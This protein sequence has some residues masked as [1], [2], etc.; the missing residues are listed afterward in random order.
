MGAGFVVGF[1]VGLGAGAVLARV[2]VVRGAFGV[3]AGRLVGATV[4]AGRGVDLATVRLGAG[5]VVFAVTGLAVAEG[6][7]EPE[8][9]G[10]TLVE[11]G[12]DD[13]LV[14]PFGWAEGAAPVLGA[15]AATRPSAVVARTGTS[16]ARRRPVSGADR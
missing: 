16:H 7:G 6:V 13:E 5:L 14:T 9:E 15:H 8:G 12:A 4:T 3:V 2:G 1:V 10:G 11:E